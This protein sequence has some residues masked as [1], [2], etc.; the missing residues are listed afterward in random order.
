MTKENDTDITSTQLSTGLLGP[1]ITTLT[2]EIISY[3]HNWNFFGVAGLLVIVA[4]GAILLSLRFFG[5]SGLYCFMIVAVVSSNVQV[6]KA[7]ETGFTKYPLTLG[8]MLFACTYLVTD[9]LAEYYDRKFARRAIMLGFVAYF[10]FNIIM[11]LTLGFKPLEV[12][13]EL[14]EWQWARDNHNYM[15]ML[16][17]PAPRFFIASAA[18][19]LFGQYCNVWVFAFIRNILPTARWLWLRNTASTFL[20]ALIDDI[21]FSVLAWYL[22]TDT[23]L[24]W[25]VIVYTYI[26]GCFGIRMVMNVLGIPIIYLARYFKPKQMMV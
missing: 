2:D 11:I 26:L 20:A 13:P 4:F 19:Y 15:Y 18:S 5:K 9:V 23:P 14:Q 16:F 7:V 10:L 24:A 21:V 22:L 6:L 8:T 17:S 3:L 12:G 1:M 25:D